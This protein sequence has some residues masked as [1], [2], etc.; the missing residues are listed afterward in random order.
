MITDKAYPNGYYKFIDTSNCLRTLNITLNKDEQKEPPSEREMSE[1]Q[2]EYSCE[3]IRALIEIEDQN[4]YSHWGVNIPAKLRALR[5][6]FSGK[7]VSGGSTITEQYVKNKYFKNQNRSYLQKAREA[8]LALYF[9]ITRSKEK[10]LNIYYHDAYFGNNLYGLGAALEVY[11][12]KESLDELTQEEIVILL[13]LLNNPSINNVEERYFQEYF[14][15]VK[16]RLGYK[17]EKT[18]N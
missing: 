2:R 8:V 10:I 16:S 7:R 6:N 1:G 3:F 5:D 15:Q 18:Y 9:N 11:F 4:Y 13:S 17:F 12:E 14:E